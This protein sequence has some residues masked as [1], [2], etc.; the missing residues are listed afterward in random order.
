MENDTRKWANRFKIDKKAKD[1]SAERG[2]VIELYR[3]ELRSKL[4][5]GEIAELLQLRGKVLGCWCKPEACHGDVL[6]E[7]I[8]EYSKK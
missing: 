7:L 1:A 3:K 6:L 4:E 2:R 8:E 5:S